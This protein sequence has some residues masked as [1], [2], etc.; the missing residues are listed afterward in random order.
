MVQLQSVQ[1]MDQD[2]MPEFWIFCF[3]S[4]IFGRMHG[5]VGFWDKQGLRDMHSAFITKNTS[6][7]TLAVELNPKP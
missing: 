6:T 7:A 3:V 2:S 5:V 4:T 1:G